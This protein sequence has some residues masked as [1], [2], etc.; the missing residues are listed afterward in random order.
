MYLNL[1]AFTLPSYILQPLV[2][3]MDQLDA[4]QNDTYDDADEDSDEDS[5][6]E[7]DDGDDKDVQGADK[8]IMMDRTNGME[9]V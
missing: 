5:D 8:G 6:E 3:K 7:N 2:L 1:N 9:W 4:E